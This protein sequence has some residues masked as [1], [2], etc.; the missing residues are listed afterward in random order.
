MSKNLWILVGIVVIA[1]AVVAGVILMQPSAADILVQSLESMETIDDAHAV[2]SIDIDTLEHDGSGKLEIWARHGEDDTGAFRLEVLETDEEKA[3]RA[4]IVSDGETLWAYSPSENK[5]FVGTPEDAKAFMEE[6]QDL[7]SEFEQFDEHRK[8]K[9]EDGEYQHPENAEA[10]IEKLQEYA[11]ISKSGTETV[12]GENATLLKIEPIPE[13]MPSE[14]AAVG[15]LVNLWV[16][17]DSHLPLAVSFTGSSMGEASIAL[18]ELDVNTG[19]ADDLFTFEIPDDAVVVTFAD[20]QPQSL[21][22]EEAGTTAAFELLTPA[23]TPSG[24]TLVD[25]LEVQGNLVQRYT[26]PE[27]GSFTV[28]QGMVGEETPEMRT[29]STE[30]L[31]V[32]VR[33]TT[34]QLYES[35]D[36]GRVLLT[37]SEGELVFVIAGDL[38]S[39]QVLTIAD[40][41]E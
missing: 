19:L 25:I 12:A 36:G 2:V 16:G 31:A 35:E 18:T 39:E 10:A 15:G 34:G 6:N 13:Q 33:G 27:G 8:S 29:P 32:D 26:L 20:L 41:L 21:T 7:L 37:W 9:P 3:Q 40:S 5:V 23:E 22:L 4:V 14:Y 30:S 1:A 17:K 24:A 38:T 28:A 11:N